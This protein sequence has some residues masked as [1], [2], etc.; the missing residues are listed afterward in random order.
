MIM[1]K[2]P[3]DLAYQILREVVF[4]GEDKKSSAAISKLLELGKIRRIAPKI[5]TTNFEAQDA[6]IVKRNL[7]PIIGRLYP[8]AILSH[9]TAFECMP[10]SQGDI[11]LTYKYTRK[12]SL[13]GI[14]VH[15]LE[16]PKVDERDI[17]FVD[18]YTGVFRR[19]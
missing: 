3:T 4:A 15:L 1:E 19:I 5:Y 18:G 6:D 14:T 16:G 11:Y 7:F 13:P 12:V 10:T 17:P 9:R 2:N 8:G